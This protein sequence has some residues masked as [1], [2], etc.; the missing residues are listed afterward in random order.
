MAGRTPPG[1]SRTGSEEGPGPSSRQKPRNH[2]FISSS[3]WAR[4]ETIPIRVFSKTFYIFFLDYNADE[5]TIFSFS[6]ILKNYEIFVKLFHPN[7][8]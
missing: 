7:P 1:D 5:N 8:S 6:Q 4:V 3:G 2:I